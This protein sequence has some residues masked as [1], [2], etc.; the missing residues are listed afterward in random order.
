MDKGHVQVQNKEKHD[1]SML[2]Q[3]EGREGI[4]INQKDYSCQATEIIPQIGNHNKINIKIK[5]KG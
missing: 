1:Y 3:I 5:V 2:P 4:K